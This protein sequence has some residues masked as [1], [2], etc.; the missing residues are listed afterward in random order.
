MN[1]PVSPEIGKKCPTGQF[2]TNYHDVGDGAP[3]LMIH[4]SGPGVSAWANWR[5]VLA[6]MGKTNRVV[7][8]DMVGFGYTE[9]PEGRDLGI[10]VWLDQLVSLLD[11]LEL[12][13]V[14]LVGNSF[15]G[16]IALHFTRKY[17]QRVAKLALMGAVSSS[18][19]ITEGLDKVWGY[20]PSHENM[21]ELMNVFVHNKGLISEDLI[22]LRF[23]ASKQR[24]MDKVY[25]S[26][27]PAP[28]Q[29]WVDVLA[30]PDE[31]LRSIKQPTLIL[32][33]RDDQV[34]PFSASLRAFDL[35]PNASLLAFGGCGHWTQIEK[36]NEF[37]RAVLAFF[38]E[39]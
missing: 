29:Q 21:R 38:N 2:E 8:P 34:I 17:P 5:G 30:L 25:E 37:V 23:E 10:G 1:I 27:F 3:I 22:K 20:T 6:D 31:G 4:G 39:D 36:R 35:I 33:G 7:A 26:L 19:P 9:V 14:H 13:K 28:R 18:F 24:G 16:A 11:N 15:G 12:P 32:H